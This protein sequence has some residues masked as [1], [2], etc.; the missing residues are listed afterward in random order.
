MKKQGDCL[1]LIDVMRDMSTF[2]AAVALTGAIFRQRER[3]FF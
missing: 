3:R 1:V 2:A